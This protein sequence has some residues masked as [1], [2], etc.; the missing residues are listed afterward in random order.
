MKATVADNTLEATLKVA[1]VHDPADPVKENVTLPGCIDAGSHD[2]VVRCKGCGTEL[3]RTTVEDAALG[4]NWGEWS[5]T[6]APTCTEPGE[7]SRTCARCSEKETRASDALGHNW[8]AWVVTKEVTETED[9]EETRTCTRCKETETRTIPHLVVEYRNTKGDGN[10]WENGSSDA[11]EF[12]FNRSIEDEKAFS[13]FTGLQVDGKDLDVANYTAV[14]GSVIVKLKPE[15]LET[16]S[17]GKHTLTAV[18]D[19]GNNPSAEFTIKEKKHAAAPTPAKT[20]GTTTVTKK[21]SQ[22]AAK[23]S[24]KSPKTGDSSSPLLWISLLGISLFVI[25]KGVS[26]RRKAKR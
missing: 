3:S 22:S 13:H 21:T 11:L 20:S 10:T 16:L 1:V 23:G 7:E 2:E 24:A 12:V 18:F 9:G 25:A 4:H 8:G 6:K 15:Y 5:E 19:D 14:S 26:S 17:A